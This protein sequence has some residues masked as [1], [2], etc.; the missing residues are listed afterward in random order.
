MTAKTARTYILLS[1]LAALLT[2]GLKLAAFG[3]TGSVGLLSDALESGVNLISA[4]VAFWALSLAAK[5]PDAE[6]PFGHSKA[7]YFSSGLE[8]ALILVA[9]LTIAWAAWG[10][11]FEPQPL[12]TPAGGITLALLA[13]AI[14]GIVAWILLRAGGRLH[15]IALRADAHHLFTDVWTSLG[16]VTAV[17]VVA[18]TGWTVLDPLIALAVAANIVWIA[19]GLMRETLSGLLDQSIDRAQIDQITALFAPYEEQNIRFH[20]LRTRLAGTQC[21]ISFHVLVPGHWTVQDGHDLC[22][23]LETAIA[24]LIPGSHVTTH[25]EPLED[26]R[27]WQHPPL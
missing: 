8:S 19:V 9:A 22:E 6:H 11:L 27:S 17:A 21:F 13:T 15:S 25:L 3:V 24:A 5:P 14:N 7:E 4:L 20:L 18:L 2:M 12:Q 26:P 1:L 16:V 23:R 10:R